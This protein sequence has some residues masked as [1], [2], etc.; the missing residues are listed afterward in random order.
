MDTISSAVE[1][2]IACEEI[3]VDLRSLPYNDDLLHVLRNI[4]K[5]VQELSMKEV[6]ARRIKNTYML[7]EHTNKINTALTHLRHLIL[8]A[9]LME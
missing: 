8:I 3:L 5:M 2:R 6:T 1:G 7:Q 4:E 9:K